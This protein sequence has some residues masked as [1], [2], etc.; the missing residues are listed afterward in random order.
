MAL[1]SVSVVTN[2]LR[3]R[4]FTPPATAEEIANPPLGARL[5][6]AGYLAGIAAIA[7]AIGAGWFIWL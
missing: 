7:L 4:R 1:S 3:L 2:S 6:E 5:A